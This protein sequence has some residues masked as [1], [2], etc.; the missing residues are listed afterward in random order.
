MLRGILRKTGDSR[1]RVRG[2]FIACTI[3]LATV[4]GLFVGYSF[5]L[6]APMGFRVDVMSAQEHGPICDGPMT[7]IQPR[8]NHRFRINDGADLDARELRQG[9]DQE[10]RLR[11]VKVIFLWS[12]ADIPYS[13]FVEMVDTVYRPD[14]IIT[15]LTHKALAFGDANG[16]C[17]LPSGWA[18]PRKAPRD[19]SLLPNGLK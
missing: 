2:S 10:L 13:D 17:F 4:L 15:V 8:G 19:G 7:V 14:A 12:E 3:V 1:L 6:A 5:L 18:A 9:L 11:A 16:G